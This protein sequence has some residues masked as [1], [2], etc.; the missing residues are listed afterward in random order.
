MIRP[1]L[2]AAIPAWAIVGNLAKHDARRQA[3]IAQPHFPGPELADTSRP[4]VPLS[5]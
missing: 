1:A 5:R 4:A 3:R 2:L